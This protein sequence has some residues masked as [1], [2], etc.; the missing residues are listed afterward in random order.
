VLSLELRHQ[1]LDLCMYRDGGDER[2]S[3]F[4]KGFGV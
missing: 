1:I 3:V 2:Q 4:Q